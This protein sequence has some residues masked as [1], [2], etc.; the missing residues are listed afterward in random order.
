MFV[1]I[2]FKAGSANSVL[3][4]I[5]TLFASVIVGQFYFPHCCKTS[6]RERGCEALQCRVAAVWH[7][8]CMLI[9][10]KV[11][12]GQNVLYEVCGRCRVQRT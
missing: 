9:V 12:F 7:Q 2:V 11:D 10:K 3:L 5:Y 1:S 6:N 4:V 8:Y